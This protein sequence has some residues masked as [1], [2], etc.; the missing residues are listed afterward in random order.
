MNL[1]VEEDQELNVVFT[2]VTQIFA[3]RHFW[4]CKLKS[5]CLRPGLVFGV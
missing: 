1:K 5:W 3:K 4:G 2:A